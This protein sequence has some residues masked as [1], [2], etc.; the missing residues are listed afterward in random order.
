MPARKKLPAIPD[1]EGGGRNPDRLLVQKS[2]PL[3]TLSETAMTLAEFKILDAYLSR[4]DS[5]DPENRFVRLEKGEIEKLLEVS[6]IKPQ[7]L[8]KRV[9]NLFQTVTI[10]DSR[11]RKGFV[12][13]ALFERAACYQ[14]DDG[15]WVVDL[16]ASPSAMQYVFNIENLGYL[17]YRLKNVVNLTSRYSYIMY[18]YLENERFRKSWEVDLT[19]LKAMLRC[20]AETY[21]QFKRFNDLVLKKVHKELSEKTDC[22][23]TYEPV[24]KGRA[25]RAVRFTLEVQPPV[26]LPPPPDPDQTVIGGVLEPSDRVE[27]LRGA[28]VAPGADKPAFSYQEMCYVVAELDKLPADCL[29]EYVSG[30]TQAR[31]YQYLAEKYALMSRQELKRPIKDP[32]A[33]LLKIIDGDVHAAQERSAKQDESNRRIR[34]DM[35]R[36]RQLLDR[37][38]EQEVTEQVGV[39]AF[40]PSS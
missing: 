20:T 23:Y 2:N 13:I 39:G 14:D 28:C 31:Q 33:Y 30:G 37:Y 21:T 15:L 27:Y 5:H 34:E 1:Y 10:R 3:M 25:V 38:K 17:R 26:E 18:L 16:G 24:K 12:K 22:R 40:A 35:E 4:I 7:D 9:D 19:D 32:L 11:K 6:Q 8:E 36:A 29:P